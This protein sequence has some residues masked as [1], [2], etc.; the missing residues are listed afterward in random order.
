MTTEASP[1]GRLLSLTVHELRTPV[2]VVAGYLR[3]VLKDRAGPVSDAQRKLLEEAEKSCARLSAL[4]AELSELSN[5]ERGLAPFNRQEADAAILLSQA[6][7]E[8]P[9]LPDRDAPIDLRGGTGPAAVHGDPVRLRAAIGSILAAIRRELVHQ[10]PLVVRHGARTWEGGPV[11]W[12]SLGDA[13]TAAALD[14]AHP[15]LAAFDEWR[16]GVGLTLPLARRVIE[17][18]GGRVWSPAGD[19]RRSGAAIVL[20]LK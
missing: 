4:L 13:A 7:E 17:A 20:P 14:G 6:V 5:V 11:Y 9:S 15:P 12:I 19:D 18:H 16:G 3:M 10:T 2:T 1:L 8:L